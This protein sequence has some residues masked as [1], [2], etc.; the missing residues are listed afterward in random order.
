MSPSQH[1]SAD[2]LRKLGWLL[3][4]VAI[5]VIFAGMGMRAPWLADEPRFAQI[6]KEMVETGQWFFPA[7][8]GELYPDK[9]PVFM[10]T[11]ALFYKL[12]GNLSLAFLLPSALC[13][14]LTIFLVYDLGKRLWSAQT[15]L[16][17]AALLL[18]T[19]QFTLQSKT[20][21]IDAMV[22]CWITLGC[23]GLMR[24][25]CD[26][27]NWRWYFIAWFFMG[28]GVI[29][30][31]VGFLPLLML[32]PFFA[33]R[34]WRP[35]PREITGKP[36]WWLGPLF[37]LLAIGLWVVPMLLLV[38]Q[39]NNPAFDAYRDNILL[40]QTAKRYA[41]SWHHIK[42][43]WYYLVEV[44]PVFWLPLSMMIPWLIK[45]WW[46]AIKQGDRRI[47]VPLIWVMLVI[48]FFSLSPGK[49]GVY[50]LP[51]VPMLALIC[52]PYLQ[53]LL[54]RAWPKRILWSIVLLIAALLTL[55]GV[56]GLLD[57]HLMAKL[58]DQY[59][60]RPWWMLVT[61]GTIGLIISVATYRKPA[62]SWLLFAPA[63]WLIYS[64]WGYA[65]LQPVRT[66][67]NV[68]QNLAKVH[69][70]SRPVA[71]LD[72]REQFLLFSRWPTYHFGYHADHNLEYQQAWQWLQ[73]YPDGVVLAPADLPLVCFDLSNAT[74][75]GNAHRR[76]YYALT[77]N[78][79]LPSC[80]APTDY[81]EYYY[82]PTEQYGNF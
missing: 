79:A 28:L 7:R 54:S 32:I 24:H 50:M 16:I 68:L 58:N 49:R 4:A 44:I 67:V 39:A 72:F 82:L 74:S 36:N 23:Y 20:A 64:L 37:F 52:A 69:D 78:N 29:T 19:L 34:K 8:G 70:V 63:L 26:G 14:L 43:F 38:E 2:T 80:A 13:A 25:F 35:Q 12:T 15:G 56:L 55:A 5:V 1:V 30:K 42:P 45:P 31:G 27:P 11:I 76:D 65:V 59:P 71:M 10:W 33:M 47:A 60:V 51:A 9:P 75:L 62:N 57:L 81:R 40:K 22:C 18:L 53:Q 17:A 61:L 41:D 48:L 77:I 21:Q 3:V 66:P 46:Q 6:A 73:R